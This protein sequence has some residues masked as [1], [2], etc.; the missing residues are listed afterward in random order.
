MLG[1][2]MNSGRITLD[3]RGRRLL[4][5]HRERL[6]PTELD[7]VMPLA[8]ARNE[9]AC[10]SSEAQSRLVDA[11]GSRFPND[12]QPRLG[13]RVMA[14]LDDRVSAGAVALVEVLRGS[15]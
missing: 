10:L 14:Y 11:F 7:R 8:Q 5:A 4:V 15:S 6:T 2:S 3:A 1:S 13:A 12:P 9:L